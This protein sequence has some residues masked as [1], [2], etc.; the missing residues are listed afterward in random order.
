MARH[1]NL[2]A[3]QSRAAKPD[4]RGLPVAAVPLTL[5][6]VLLAAAAA[7]GWSHL[8]ADRLA[9]MAAAAQ[10]PTPAPAGP[11]RLDPTVVAALDRQVRDREA[12]ARALTGDARGHETPAPAS[13]WLE[14]LADAAQPS[15]AV[16]TLRLE[17][18]P[19]L[20]L[21]G[22]ARQPAD[23]N[24]FIARLQAHPL[25]GTAAIG[26]LEMRRGESA[27]DA[28]SFRLTPPPPEGW[29]AGGAPS[30]VSTVEAR[31]RHIP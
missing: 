1:L 14:A 26:Q 15:V 9:R 28:L 11:A 13:R 6:G 8:G 17:P 30:A 23:I 4:R 21:A 20:S 18:G 10:A 22:A 24:G 3:A 5:G 27:G 7:A 2:L 19:R 29:T 16:N 12:L 25:S 31:P